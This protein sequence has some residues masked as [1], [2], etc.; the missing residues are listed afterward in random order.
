MGWDRILNRTWNISSSRVSL[1]YTSWIAL[2]NL[3]Y[4]YSEDALFTSSLVHHHHDSCKI[5]QT[6]RWGHCDCCKFGNCCSGS[7]GP[8]LSERLTRHVWVLNTCPSR[9]HIFS[10]PTWDRAIGALSSSNIRCLLGLAAVGPSW[11]MFVAHMSSV[12]GLCPEMAAF[13]R[14]GNED[15]TRP[16]DRGTHL[17][18]H[19]KFSPQS[20]IMT[21]QILD[22]P[23]HFVQQ[24]AKTAPVEALVGCQHRTTF[25]PL[26]HRECKC[27]LS[28]PVARPAPVWF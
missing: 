22:N 27:A 20:C 10:H 11:S 17:V 26:G 13:C 3:Q 8:S 4:V 2:S 16:Q 28:C 1:C 19:K 23:I 7:N 14:L 24:R 12:C 25:D 5:L 18:T 15:F 21:C 9:C 6:S